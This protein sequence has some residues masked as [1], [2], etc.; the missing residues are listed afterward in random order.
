MVKEVLLK[1]KK[2]NTSISEKKGRNISKVNSL[3][4]SE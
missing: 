3:V 4:P 2:Q 1:L